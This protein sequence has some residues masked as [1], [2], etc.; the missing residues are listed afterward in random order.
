MTRHSTLTN[1]SDLHYAKVRSFSGDPAIV[2][3]EFANQLIVAA[4]TNKIYRAIDSTQGAIVELEAKNGNDVSIGSGRPLNTPL[5]IG[6]IYFDS[7]SNVFYCSVI[8]FGNLVWES[9][10]PRIEIPFLEVFKPLEH[11]SPNAHGSFS[12]FHGQFT[13]NDIEAYK[14]ESISLED[15][16]E[17]ED[18]LSSNSDLEKLINQYG[19]GFY[20]FGFNL[21]D[22][23]NLVQTYVISPYIT[24]NEGFSPRSIN[25]ISSDVITH[26]GKKC[27]GIIQVSKY[28][29]SYASFSLSLQLTSIA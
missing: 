6:Q 9:S 28:R 23:D 13:S 14:Y 15:L 1:P 7:I 25:F 22:P 5:E 21:T 16:D 18:N 24:N 17:I 10:L 3:P 2:T 11:V 4:D 27:E 8:W 20:G 12:V 29:R 19:S 26:L